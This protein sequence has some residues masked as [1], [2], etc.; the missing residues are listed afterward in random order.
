MN[1]IKVK[2]PAK[3]NLGLNIVEKRP[4]NYHN[5]ETVFY[6]VNIFDYLT[7]TKSSINSFKTN[8]DLL[9]SEQ[10]NLI[11]KA[12]KLLEEHTKEELTSEIY[13]EKNIP[14][15]AG[16]GGGS[17]NAAA[18]L[19][20]FNQLFELE[21]GHEELANIALQLGSDVPF[22]LTPQP[23]YAELRG[24]R[25]I[26]LD[27]KIDKPILIINPNI[28]L[29]T[30]WAYE[31]ITPK[32]PSNNLYDVLVIKEIGVAEFKD[33]IT[34]DFEEPAFK[35]FPL[36]KEIKEKL[37]EQSAIFSLLSGSGSSIFSIFDDINSAENAQQFFNKN[38]KTFIHN[39]D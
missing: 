9:N 28:H 31:N 27:Y 33:Y 22:F 24:E 11:L 29:S 15:G 36:I 2:C 35:Q 1:D 6:P 39:E 38:Y 21:V 20:A 23:A 12:K 4:D 14:I 16:L 37:T 30:K 8:N 32:K 3:I 10:D 26:Y 25:L 13:L 34:N 19:N 5:I 17:S 18:A 7:I